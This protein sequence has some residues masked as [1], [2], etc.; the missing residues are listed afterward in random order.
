MLPPHKAQVIF[1]RMQRYPDYGLYVTEAKGQVIGTFALLIIDNLG[2]VGA[3]SGVVEDVAVDPAW[4]KQGVGK[5]MMR[6]AVKLCHEKGCYKLSL[7]SNQ[8]ADMPTP[9]TNRS[10]SSGT[11]IGFV[12]ICRAKRN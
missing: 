12:W 4:Q 5:T 3:P 1:E 6:Y 10:V 2:H 8:S 7:S 11:A 9:P